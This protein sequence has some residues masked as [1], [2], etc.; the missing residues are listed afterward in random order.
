[1]HLVHRT[2][3]AECEPARPTA[4][5]M[6]PGAGVGQARP[7][8]C[9]SLQAAWKHPLLVGLAVALGV[10]GAYLY[11]RLAPRGYTSGAKLYVGDAPTVLSDADDGGG[12]EGSD[13]GA[14]FSA[15]TQAAL[16][17]SAPVLESALATLSRQ[18][19]LREWQMFRDA[20]RP[21]SLLKKELMVDVGKQDG[22]IA[23]S[24]EAPEPTEAAALVNG[25]VGAYIE[26]QQ[27]Q[28]QDTAGKFRQILTDEK[29]AREKEMRRKWESVWNYKKSSPDLALGL[30]DEA[31]VVV[32]RRAL[33]STALT[34]AQLKLIEVQTQAARLNNKPKA[35]EMLEIAAENERQIRAA[36]EA[37]EQK[38]L[39]MSAQEIE[40]SKLLAEID[41]LKGHIAS[42]DTRIGLLGVND[43]GGGLNVRVV[44]PAVPVTSPSSP[45]KTLLYGLG[46]ALGLV[47]A[48]DWRRFASR[49]ECGAVWARDGNSTRCSACLSWRPSRSCP[50]A[51]APTPGGN[52]PTRS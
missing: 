12:N 52:P 51:S 30:A 48:A 1:M 19:P 4:S 10:A 16:L 37:E 44:E 49:E 11:C 22:L 40:L 43:D 28:A 50:T 39:A 42:L 35:R 2:R 41:Y 9:G 33:L 25:V 47:R 14:Y 46:A 8:P 34:A 38:A 31:N 36:F 13:T 5:S 15:H 27:R 24:L 26:S 20:A 18:R 32:Q 29:S 6:R 7:E 3:A 21:A 45:R 23:L 17:A